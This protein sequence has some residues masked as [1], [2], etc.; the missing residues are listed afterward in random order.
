MSKVDIKSVRVFTPSWSITNPDVDRADARDRVKPFSYIEWIQHVNFETRDAIDYTVE[1][2]SYVK[3]WGREN[4]KTADE[5]VRLISDRYKALLVDIT[6]NYTTPEEQRFLSNINL[7]DPRH[8][9]SALP[10][11]VSKIK[12]ITLYISRQRDIV[13]QQKV[14]AATGG[15]VAGVTREISNSILNRVL[16]PTKFNVSSSPS[17]SEP[18]F[19]VRIVELYDT[20]QVYFTQ[21]NAPIESTT[22]FKDFDTLLAEVLDECKPILVLSQN[23]KLVINNEPMEINPEAQIQELAY[24]EFIDYTKESSKLN[25]LFLDEYMKKYLGSDIYE[26]SNGEITLLAQP[27]KPWRNLLNRT[28]VSVNLSHDTTSMRSVDQIGGFFLPKNTGLLTFFSFQPELLIT[29]KTLSVDRI[30]DTSKH[31]NSVLSQTLENPIDHFEDVTWMKADISNGGLYGD[32]VDSRTHAKFAGY[33]SVDEINS[34]PQ[35]GLSR[36]TDATGFFSGEQNKTWSNED[37]FPVRGQF[38]FDIDARQETLLVGHRSMYR[39][40]TDIFG[41]EYA[42]YKQ[43]QPERGPFDYALDD[44]IDYNTDPKCEVI[45]GGS[46]LLKHKELDGE[47]LITEIF[48]GG[49]TG[50]FDPKVEQYIV[51]VPFPDLRRAVDSDDDGNVVFEEFNTSY[52][53]MDPT[54]QFPTT[55]RNTPICFHGFAPD[56]EYDRQ[57]YGSLFTDDTCGRLLPDIKVC[58]IIDNYSFAV[59]SEEL[60]SDGNH[61]SASR[62]S[63]IPGAEDAYDFYV[64]PDHDEWDENYGV[65]NFGFSGEEV[66]F[67]DDG[68]I[69]GWFFNTVVCDELKGDFEH[70]EIVEPFFDQSLD[71]GET[72][73]EDPPEKS[74]DLPVTM[75]NQQASTLGTGY[76]RSYNSE[77]IVPFEDILANMIGGFASMEGDDFQEFKN[78]VD[79]GRVLDIDVLYDV[80]IIETPNH[81][82]IEKLRFDDVAIDLARTGTNNIFIRTTGLNPE[83]ERSIGWFFNERNNEL[84]FGKTLV[85]LDESG[86]KY[87]Y[88]LIYTANLNNL[89]YKQSHPN[90]HYKDQLK[91]LFV[92][93]DDVKDYDIEMIDRPVICYNDYTNVYNISYT[94]KLSQSDRVKFVV[95]SS[96]YRYGQYNLKLKESYVYHAQEIDRYVKPG[97]EW[98]ERIDSREIKLTPDDA[99]RP[100]APSRMHTTRTESLQD[101]TG[102]PLSGFNFNIKIDTKT[103]PVSYNLNDFKIN[104][105]I[106]D[107]GDGTEPYIND[108]IMDD[109]LLPLTFDLTTLPDPSDFGDPR[110]L[111]FEHDYTFDKSVPHT[112]VATVSAVYSNFTTATYKINIETVP[113]DTDSAF[114]GLKLIGS[115]LYTD[116]QGKDRQLLILETQN[117]RWVTNV[118]IDRNNTALPTIDGF[119]NGTRY[120][121]EYHITSSGTTMTGSAPS[122]ESKIITSTPTTRHAPDYLRTQAY[123]IPGSE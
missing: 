8:I 40:R 11:Y 80:I 65:S 89:Q 118:V 86:R 53:G 16:D 109:G 1:Y 24:S 15:A 41:N 23:V 121:G 17:Q 100:I 33:T 51:P 107:P 9:E 14:L 87:V 113:Y 123:S 111:G 71:I 22:I 13:K 96:D 2:N 120:T 79:T 81:L 108:R 77:K 31:G 103:I 95:F 25:K 105:I 12:Q 7:N 102:N 83:L 47:D 55:M 60:D 5:T 19:N 69:D 54:E 91:E 28:T 63:A 45:D 32:I 82:Y 106:F 99:M 57:A 64:H 56:V 85:G 20:S 35:Q 94:G 36:S 112:Y 50:G 4:D 49:R 73:Y 58:S 110:R 48:E 10:F 67:Q 115:K 116:P 119:V 37:V 18:Y 3:T 43:I 44:I 114:D 26:I 46:T 34:R 78:D 29:N 27:E 66:E 62:P 6:L 75:Y 93:P 72:A 88:P 98:E 42:L 21:N 68:D 39:W 90:K 84:M 76:F 101:M 52:Y 61:I 97:E 59:Y 117:P 104:R 30:Q 38:N 70:V 74:M 122:P 92:L